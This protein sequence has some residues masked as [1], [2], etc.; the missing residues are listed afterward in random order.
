[1]RCVPGQF[2]RFGQVVFQRLV[3]L[4]FRGV[5]LFGVH[6]GAESKKGLSTILLCVVSGFP[7]RA[8]IAHIPTAPSGR[9]DPVRGA[10]RPFRRRS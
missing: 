5:R 10:A 8:W 6:R 4:F 3:F 7:L 2:M 1:M 9:G